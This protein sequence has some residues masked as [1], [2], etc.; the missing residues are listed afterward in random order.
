[1]HILAEKESKGGGRFQHHIN[2]LSQQQKHLF[3]M[4]R[5]SALSYSKLIE[6]IMAIC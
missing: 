4:L 2:K 5:L 1:M 6:I 3:G